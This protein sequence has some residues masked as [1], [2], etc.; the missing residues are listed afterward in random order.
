MTDPIYLKIK[1]NYFLEKVTIVKCLDLSYA[2]E[3]GCR[4][5]WRQSRYILNVFLEDKTGCYHRYR[6]R[7]ESQSHLVQVHGLFD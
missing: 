2:L 5:R 4:G 6:I 3:E 7:D 1:K